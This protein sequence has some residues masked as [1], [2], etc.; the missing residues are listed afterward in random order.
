LIERLYLYGAKINYMS[1]TSQPHGEV[2]HPATP[3]KKVERSTSYPAITIEDAI[4]FVGEVYKNFRSSIAKR[5]DIA[6]VIEGFNHRQLAASSYYLLLTREKDTY[7]V[8]NTYLILTNPVL[9]KDRKKTEIEKRGELLKCFYAPKLYKQ[10]IEKFDGDVIP[11]TLIAHL[12]RFHGITPDAAPTAADV[13]LRNAKYCDLLSD[14]NKLNY[15]LA[16]ARIDFSEYDED[17]TP[18]EELGQIN[19]KKTELN[20]NDSQR[21]HSEKN[22][23]TPL[24]IPEMLNR[25]EIKIKLTAGK[26]AVLIHPSVLNS[27]DIQI[28][29]KQ[30]EQL[31]LI[32]SAPS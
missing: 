27:T 22:I 29:K 8:S 18:Y 25:E 6:S 13:F 21:V 14:G 9:E 28:L 2:A 12:V 30:I 23:P 16:E 24:Q 4:K 15:K 11:D 32:I 26:F 3:S 5:D 7:Q 1:D 19:E 17:N 10:L 31:E 20:K